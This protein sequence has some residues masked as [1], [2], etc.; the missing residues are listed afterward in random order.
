M[1]SASKDSHKL[2]CTLLWWCEGNK[3]NAMIRF[4]NSD[5]TL[6]AN[7]LATLR[8]G[9]DIKEEKLRVLMYLHT[10]HDN[11]KQKQFWS[12][13]TYIPITVP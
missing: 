8:S 3:D 7:F 1:S 9:F 4:T 12:R 10:Y 13:I 6:I 5:P 11:E 2:F